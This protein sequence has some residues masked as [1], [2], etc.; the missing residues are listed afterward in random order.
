LI[1]L[2]SLFAWEVFFV[3]RGQAQRV[4]R[5]LPILKRLV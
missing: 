1:F 4:E 5:L 3:L 2:H